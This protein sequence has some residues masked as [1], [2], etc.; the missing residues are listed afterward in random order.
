MAVGKGKHA[1]VDVGDGRKLMEEVRVGKV[2]V[3]LDR[4]KLVNVRRTEPKR[5]ALELVKPKQLPLIQDQ[6]KRQ[7]PIQ[8]L[9]L[10]YSCTGEDL[11]WARNG[12]LASV[13]NGEATPVV[14]TRIEDAGF[15]DLNVIPFGVDRVFIRSVLDVK[16]STILEGA[17]DFFDHIFVN[18]GWWDKQL[19]PRQRG[20]WL[21]LYGIPLHAWNEIFFKLCVLDC[22]RFLWTDCCS[23]DRDRFDY[24]RIL[25]ATSSLEVVDC[26]EKISVDG[27][28]VEIRIIEEFGFNIG[29]DVCLYDIDDGTCSSNA[30]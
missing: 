29:D 3:L 1:V 5:G 9:L 7:H 4:G 21:R 2:K 25:I 30:D 28:V 19:V 8:K 18:I 26:V 13:I 12:F 27:E 15:K 10:S 22:G 20:A 16:A 14:Q 24:A 17:K 11:Q 6:V 23:M